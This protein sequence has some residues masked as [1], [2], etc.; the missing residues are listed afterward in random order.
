MITLH[1]S[2]LNRALWLWSEGE[3]IGEQKDLKQALKRLELKLSPKL[4]TRT[5]YAWLPSKGGTPLPSNPLLN[6]KVIPGNHKLCLR[7]YPVE[8]LPLGFIEFH[9]LLL[10]IISDTSVS[11]PGSYSLA[12]LRQVYSLALDIVLKENFIPGLLYS[13]QKW[14]AVWKA[15]PDDEQMQLSKDLAAKMPGVFRCLST[16]PDSEPMQPAWTIFSTLLAS[17]VDSFGRDRYLSASKTEADNLH[18]AWL[19][20]LQS[21]DPAIKW[22]NAEEIMDLAHTLEEWGRRVNLVHESQMKLCFK[23]SEPENEQ[24]EWVLEYLLQSKQG[25]GILIPLENYW[26]KDKT[27]LNYLKN[28][29]FDSVQ[30]PLMLLEQAAGIYPAILP[31]LEK[32]PI[33]NLLL[34]SA[35]AF[36]FL[37]EY[38]PPLSQMGFG[39]MLPAWWMGRN[40]QQKL[41]LSLKLS[42]PKMKS[43]ADL[44]L[45]SILEFDYQACLGKL[46]ISLKELESLAKLKAP[47]VQIRG[48]WTF[49]DHRQVAETIKFLKQQQQ[50]TLTVN[51]L[52]KIKLGA[53]NS[54]VPIEQVR[55]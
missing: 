17:L 16:A 26:R 11:L 29:G 49:I 21:P 50:G 18:D 36:S 35:Q 19:H 1:I 27:S 46:D 52:V 32:T 23:L 15:L 25:Q 2:Y 30:I 37:S 41:S 55:V 9:D 3:L 8:A 6:R 44:S 48:Q 42:S 14:E 54:P 22:K 4:Q 5:L 7:A 28:I 40:T 39:V 10:A 45:Q 47:L 12:W 33:H 31:S 51:E 20:A 13:D 38:V 43:K 53:S 24:A 34:D